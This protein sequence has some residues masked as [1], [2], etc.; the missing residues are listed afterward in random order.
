MFIWKIDVLFIS[1]HYDSII[2]S[3]ENLTETR[4][5]GKVKYVT[6]SIWYKENVQ[7]VWSSDYHAVRYTNTYA[8][9]YNGDKVNIDEDDIR[10][11]YD[12]SRITDVLINEL[13]NDLHNVWINYSE[14]DDEDYW[15]GGEL[16]DYI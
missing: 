5:R 8:V 3:I 9:L 4:M 11:Y 6:R 16:S 15:L 10:D 1:L 14:G 13:S 7:T 12:R 2:V